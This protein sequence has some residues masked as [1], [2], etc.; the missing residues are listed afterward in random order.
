MSRA[1][2]DD[3]PDLLD[4]IRDAQK[5][6]QTAWTTLVNEFT[7]I[8]QRVVRRALRD[9]PAPLLADEEDICQDVFLRVLQH[10]R[11]WQPIAPFS[12]WLAVVASRIVID[13][14][15]SRRDTVSID[16]ILDPPLPTSKDPDDWIEVAKCQLSQRNRRVLEL[17]LAGR[18]NRSI[19][20]ELGV[21]VRSV[22]LWL[23]EI[24]DCCR[25]IRGD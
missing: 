14:K 8:V 25:A 10:I 4:L 20:E 12:H 17:F 18:D 21:S 9:S 6:N 3:R 22:Q 13:R 7:P 16:Q 1:A 15:R 5:G 11:E 2:G 19:A 24:R 23:S